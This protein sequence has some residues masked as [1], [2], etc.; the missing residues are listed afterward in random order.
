MAKRELSCI[1]LMLIMFLS[2][3]Y[4]VFS[5]SGREGSEYRMYRGINLGNA[6]EAPKEGQWGVIIKDEY[7]RIIREAGFDAVRIPIRRLWDS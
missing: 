3:T 6:L 4:S 2:L 1:M 7:F 5:M